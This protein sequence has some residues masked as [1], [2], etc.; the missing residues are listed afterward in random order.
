MRH[1]SASVWLLAIIQCNAP[2]F[3]CSPSIGYR[4]QNDSAVNIGTHSVTRCGT[5]SL[6][7]AEVK[8]KGHF[9]NKKQWKCAVSEEE[10]VTSCTDYIVIFKSNSSAIPDHDFYN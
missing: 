3:S 6:G 9:F 7:R 5:L 8:K 2:L 4:V 1:T 10:F